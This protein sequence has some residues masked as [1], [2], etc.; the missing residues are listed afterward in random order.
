MAAHRQRVK[1]L[2]TAS[3]P[4]PVG[5]TT[6]PDSVRDQAEPGARHGG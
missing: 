6:V 4:Y 1:A 2:V 5:V 3:T